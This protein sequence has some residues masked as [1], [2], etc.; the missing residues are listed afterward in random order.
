MPRAA[1]RMREV[2]MRE[3]LMRV[4]LRMRAAM[5]RKMLMR[6]KGMTVVAAEVKTMLR[7][8]TRRRLATVLPRSA[9]WRHDGGWYCSARILSQRLFFEYPN[10]LF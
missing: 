6:V 4:A 1:L 5:M 10:F 2:L 8:M 7:A 3:V 9:T